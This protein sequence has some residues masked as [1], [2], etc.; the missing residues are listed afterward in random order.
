MASWPKPGG[1]FLSKAHVENGR[2]CR[3]A[4]IQRPNHTAFYRPISFYRVICERTTLLRL[5]HCLW[6]HSFEYCEEHREPQESG[7]TDR[8]CFNLSS[9]SNRHSLRSIKNRSTL[10]P[11]SVR[12]GTSSHDI[13]RSL[14]TLISNCRYNHSNVPIKPRP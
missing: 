6:I 14:F 10:D 8:P 2:H 1:Q 7:S 12:N 13:H 9:G 5:C 4:F 11:R 3:S